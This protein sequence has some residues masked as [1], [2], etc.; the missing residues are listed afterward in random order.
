[1]CLFR[2]LSKKFA[3]DTKHVALLV[4]KITFDCISKI[5]LGFSFIYTMGRGL[6]SGLLALMMFYYM[7][8]VMF[9]FHFILNRSP[10]KNVLSIRHWFGK[11]IYLQNKALNN[12]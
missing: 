3:L 6:F 9:A 10:A 5:L 7:F 12:C 1:M 8:G 4:A 11:I 2:N